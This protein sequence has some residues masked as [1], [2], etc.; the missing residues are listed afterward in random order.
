MRPALLAAVLVVGGFVGSSEAQPLSNSLIDLGAIH[1]RIV[2]VD[3]PWEAIRL[4]EASLQTA[5]E[6]RLRQSG[7][8]IADAESWPELSVAVLISPA[9][10][11]EITIGYSYRIDVNLRELVT[12][13]RTAEI[14]E[15]VTWASAGVVGTT[16]P[17]RT[18]TIIREAVADGIDEFSNDY[19]AANP[20]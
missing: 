11:G 9:T 19:L 16:S 12:I 4:T 2:Q 20:R 1:V 13:P 17:E 14:I 10:A 3:E 8:V 15:A 7:I 5:V 6:L 18:R